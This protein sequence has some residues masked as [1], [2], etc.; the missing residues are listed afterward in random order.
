[1]L[2]KDLG[3]GGS[4]SF[5]YGGGGRGGGGRGGRGGVPQKTLVIK[6][7]TNAKIGEALDQRCP[8]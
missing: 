7:E 4:C 6:M 2:R 8:T 3:R 1:M 5:A